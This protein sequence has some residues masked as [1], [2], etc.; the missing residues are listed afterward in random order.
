[1]SKVTRDKYITV[2]G[3]MV[4]DLHLKGNELLIYACIYGFSQAEDQV[5]NGSLQYLADWTNSTRSGVVKNLKSLVEK[6][7]IEKKDVYKNNV[8]FCEYRATE[9]YRVYNGVVQGVQQSCTG[10]A[11]ELYEGVQQ[12][13]TNNTVDN[14]RDIP[15]NNTKKKKEPIEL[16]TYFPNDEKLNEA[17]KKYIEYRREIKDPFKSIKSIESNMKKL[18][19][20]SKDEYGVMNND[21]AIEIIEQTIANGWKGLFPLKE[22]KQKK[23]SGGID[24]SKV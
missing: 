17:Y 2:L 13:C 24:W 21:T 20:M 14:T 12:S 6:G 19:K 22:E 8:K 5:F 10:C 9:L 15:V 4:A 3:W 7:L 16:S 18:E 1:M 23:V 11:T